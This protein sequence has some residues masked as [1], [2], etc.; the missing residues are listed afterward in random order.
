M[1]IMIFSFLSMIFVPNGVCVLRLVKWSKK[2]GKFLKINMNFNQ[3]YITLIRIF[4][5]NFILFH[6]ISLHQT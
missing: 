2:E 5:F 1:L 6:S 3:Y 4:I